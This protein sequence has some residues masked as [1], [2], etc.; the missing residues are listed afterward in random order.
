GGHDRLVVDLFGEFGLTVPQLLALGAQGGEPGGEGLLVE[1][2]SLERA[3][4]AIDGLLGLGEFGFDGG[5]L[6]G[7]VG[8]GGAG[9]APGCG[10]DV[11]DE[12]VVVAVEGDQRGQDG[13]VDRVGVEAGGVAS[14]VA[15]AQA[16]EA[17]VVAVG[18]G[19]AGGAGAEHRLVAA[20]AAEPAGAVV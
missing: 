16:G 11:G 4:V 8:V 7:A 1:G 10:D 5:E 15:V 14:V 17:G 12:L 20:G 6:A 9:A 2:A 19:A 3:E 18:A 13:R